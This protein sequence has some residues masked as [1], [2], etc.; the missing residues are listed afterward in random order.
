MTEEKACHTGKPQIARSGGPSEL[1]LLTAKG[2]KGGHATLMLKRK[3]ERGI[4]FAGVKI[5]KKGRHVP[6][7]VTMY[8]FN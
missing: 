5:R 6:L 4:T 3:C 8:R 1:T 7:T 2:G